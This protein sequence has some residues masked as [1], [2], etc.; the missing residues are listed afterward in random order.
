[1]EQAVRSRSLDFRGRGLGRGPAYRGNWKTRDKK[2]SREKRRLQRVGVGNE[3]QLTKTAEKE[4][5]KYSKVKRG[6]AWKSVK[7]MHGGRRNHA[8]S[9]LPK[10]RCED[11]YDLMLCQSLGS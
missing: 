6:A 9:V 2:G 1:M 5:R 3:E 7:S 8:C 4:P 10:E 11:R